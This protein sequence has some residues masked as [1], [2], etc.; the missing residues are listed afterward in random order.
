[1]RRSA[2]GAPPACSAPRARPGASITCAAHSPPCAT[3]HLR[4]WAEKSCASATIGF[5][6]GDASDRFHFLPGLHHMFESTIAG[7][8]PKPAWLAEPDRLWAPWRL[9]GKDLIEGKRD[10]TLLAVKIQEDAGIDI[11]G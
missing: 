9:E 2:A 1:M 4:G 10:A 11:V 7:S 3:P 8:L 6:I 5:M